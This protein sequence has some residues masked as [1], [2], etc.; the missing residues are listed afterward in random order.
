M[1]LI[2][3]DNRLPEAEDSAAEPQRQRRVSLGRVLLN[4]TL[5]FLA[6]GVIFACLA[7]VGVARQGQR[8]FHRVAGLFTVPT[9][10]PTATPQ[11]DVAPLVLRQVRGLSE[12]TTTEFTMQTVV[13]AQQGRTLGPFQFNTRLLYVAYGQV[14]AGVDLSQLGPDGVQVR[15]QRAIVVRLPPPRILDRKLDVE[16]SYVYDFERGILA[17]Q[18]SDLQTEAERRALEQILAGACESDIL[19]EANRR[20]ELAVGALLNALGFE[21]IRVLTQPPNPADNPCARMPRG[22]APGLPARPTAMPGG[23]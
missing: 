10:G 3:D 17:P 8:F 5:V 12:L 6:A 23:G 9:P 2:E 14:R 18:A 19:G 11:I 1:G 20:A 15:D 4:L 16:R 21:E 22:T 13:T 7:S